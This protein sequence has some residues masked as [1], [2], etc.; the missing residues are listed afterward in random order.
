MHLF[1]SRG[2]EG[3]SLSDL[4]EALGIN[5]PSLYA[6]FGNKEELFRRACARYSERT[7][8]LEQACARATAREAVETFLHGAADNMVHPEHSGCMLVTSCLAGSDESEAVRRVLSEARRA[9]VEHW[10]KRFQRAREEGDLPADTDPAALAQYVMAISHGM[11]VHARS[12]ATR[13]ELRAVADLA[14]RIWP[15]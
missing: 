5:R 14:M 1:W 8:H 13:E 3:T 6:V 10:R 4:T 11:T 2:Y 7:E 9:T 15:H 12:G